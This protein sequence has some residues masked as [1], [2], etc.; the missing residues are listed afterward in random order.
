MTYLIQSYLRSFAGTP[1]QTP[2]MTDTRY[3]DA[4][5]ASAACTI[6]IDLMQACAAADLSVLRLSTTR[7]VSSGI[8]LRN[9][10]TTHESFSKR[11]H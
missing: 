6:P 8:E 9:S 2:T 4:M 7:G 11:I 5:I 10:R 3:D 1:L